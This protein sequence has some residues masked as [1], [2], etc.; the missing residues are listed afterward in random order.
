MTACEPLIGIGC[1]LAL[2][3]L[4]LLSQQGL[5]R[6]ERRGVRLCALAVGPKA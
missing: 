4:R 3:H 5:V 2:Y 1:R 6:L